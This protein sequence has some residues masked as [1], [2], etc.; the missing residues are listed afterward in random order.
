M[1]AYVTVFLGAGI[2]GAARHGINQIA[3]KYFGIS[4][5][6]GTLIVNIVGS[7]LMGVLI[8]LFAMHGEVSQT[9]RLFLAVG[10]LGGFT[11]FSAFSLEIALMF[12]RE[13]YVT[14][15]AYAFAA[16]ILSVASLFFGLWVMK[17][18]SS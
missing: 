9:W 17:S 14:G 12:Q 16:V 11:T 8:S 10:V 7:L 18:S 5:P 1:Q 4:F 13:Q 2:G 3:A 6:Y 15:A